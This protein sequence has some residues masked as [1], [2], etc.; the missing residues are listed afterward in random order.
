MKKQLLATLGV[1][2]IGIASYAATFMQVKTDDGKIVRYDVDHVTEVDFMT[3]EIIPQDTTPV[4]PS[5]TSSSIHPYVDLGLPSGTLWA[6]YNIG[7]TKPEEYGDYFAWGETEPKEVYDWSTYKYAKASG[8]WDLDS[9]TKYNFGNYYDGVVDS[10]STLLPED[11][12]ATVNWGSEWRMPTN[13]E[14]R[15]LWDECYVVWTNSY[16]GREV[17]GIIVYK[18]KSAED[19]GE[20]VGSWQTPS[21]DYSTSDS[22][23]FFPAAGYRVGSDVSDVGYFGGYWS[24]SLGEKSE[25]YARLLRF[26]EKR[27]YWDYKYYRSNGFP[28]RAVRAQK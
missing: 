4:I 27:A 8:A 13:E 12:A 24:S 6:T 2:A 5:D 21:E 26:G 16:N 22:H 25:D 11:D 7:A 3:E 19:K 10:L 9:L 28:V 20:F 18:A 14:Q 15:E 23:V 1:G 17:R